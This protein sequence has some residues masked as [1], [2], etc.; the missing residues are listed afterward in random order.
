MKKLKGSIF[1]TANGYH[2]F[3]DEV[4]NNDL[5][6]LKREIKLIWLVAQ[7]HSDFWIKDLYKRFLSA[8]N[9]LDCKEI[10]KSIP[11]IVG[12]VEHGLFTVFDIRH[13]SYGL[14]INE[15]L[16]NKKYDDGMLRTQHFFRITKRNENDFDPYQIFTTEK[17][18]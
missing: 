5:E 1:R 17:L 12:H 10:A 3:I 11:A 15:R 4:F 2:L 7:M 9:Y 16:R 8:T 6:Y 18:K 14:T 13:F